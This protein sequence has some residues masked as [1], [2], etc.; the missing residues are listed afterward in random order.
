MNI[1][2][3]FQLG[4]FTWTVKRVKRLKDKYGDCSLDKQTMRILDTVSPQL[5]EQTFC[6]ELVHAI[7][8]SMGEQDHDEVHT[9]AFATLLH[10]FLTTAK[11]EE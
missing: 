4:G 3:Q 7:K 10:Q 8:F 2:T 11:Y 9:D 1:P 6:H 5:K